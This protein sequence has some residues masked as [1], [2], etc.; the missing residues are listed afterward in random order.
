MA[1]PLCSK[2]G[3]I[4]A[5]AAAPVPVPG[6]G[7]CVAVY[8]RYCGHV[9]SVVPSNLSENIQYIQRQLDSLQQTVKQLSTKLN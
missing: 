5:P 6:V 9:F 1:Q 4:L 3:S 8:C 2:C 7:D